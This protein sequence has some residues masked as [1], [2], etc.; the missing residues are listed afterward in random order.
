MEQPK[1]M[2]QQQRADANAR[3]W[4]E[5]IDGIGRSIALTVQVFLHRGFGRNY[6]G[7]GFIG[8]VI[9]YLFSMFFPPHDIPV[10]LGF[11]AIYGVLWLIALVNVGI[12]RWRRINDR[13]SLYSGRPHLWRLL[14]SWKETNVK[15]V[16]VI[17][18][19]LIGFAVHCVNRPL[20]D[21]LM[22]AT[23]FVFV[24][25]YNLAMQQRD[26]AIRMNDRMIE[27]R[28]LAEQLREIQGE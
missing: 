4:V 23:A 13:H 7:S 19:F 1:T 12:R 2:L 3:L 6:V 21:Y 26:R 18:A 16:E 25:E 9:I 17:L 15:H 10:L 11:A 14:P 28:V 24:R 5:F 8:V 27:Q 20:G 22:F